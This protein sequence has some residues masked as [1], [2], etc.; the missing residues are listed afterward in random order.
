MEEKTPNPAPVSPTPAPLADAKPVDTYS[1]KG[2]LNSDQF[3]KRA[4][5]VYGYSF[6]GSLMIVLPFIAIVFVIVLVVG[7]ALIISMFMGGNSDTRPMP[8]VSANMK[9]NIDK[10]CEGTVAYT[11]FTDATS[12]KKYIDDCK[13]GQHPEVI[14]QYKNSLN[15]DSG[16]AI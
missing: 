15:L 8:P 6:I 14:E 10:V 11:D 16:V 12:A 5:G 9:I 4:L 13:A 2:W 1:Y 3:W 7:A